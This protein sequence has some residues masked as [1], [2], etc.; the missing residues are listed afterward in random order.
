[1]AL[2]E[3]G[4]L[5]GTLLGEGTRSHDHWLYIDADGTLQFYDS[6]FTNSTP[7]TDEDSGMPIEN[8]EVRGAFVTF[9]GVDNILVL[10]ADA[11]SDGVGQLYRVTRPSASSDGVAKLLTNGDGEVIELALPGAIL[12]R[13]IPGE[14]RRWNDTEAFY[15]SE[16]ASIF[17]SEVPA[18]VTRV[19]AD[20]WSAIEIES[21]DAIPSFTP[22]IFVRVDGGFFWAPGFTP[23]LIY[24]N[25]DDP[26]SWER[27]PLPNA[28]QTDESIIL[29]SAGD[30]VYYQSTDDE[31]V[32]FNV[33]TQDTVALADARWIGAS[34]DSEVG[35]EIRTG[36]IA[37]QELATVLVHLADNRLGAVEA[38]NPQ[39]GIVIL[40]ELP[41]TTEEVQ[42][43]G[44]AIGPARLVRVEHEDGGIEV[45]A[46]D[47]REA[48][49][50]RRIMESPAV[51]WTY[52]SAIGS[53]PVDID[54]RPGAT[55]PLNLF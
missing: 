19:T 46:I 49:S 26:S 5:L 23:E 17:D 2:P 9:L 20:G 3:D 25:G 30:W 36:L 32:A 27:T 7:V 48:G 13:T 39:D 4:T 21:D 16:G 34:L 15:F 38:A 29:S 41:A 22:E 6:E 53:T 35:D 40:G 1:M 37:R 42:V 47:T 11:E 8:L 45:V 10:L 44:P 52:E 50:L 31:A 33:K 54:V 43:S 55:R 51:E 18:R 24:P 28:P 14:A 12:G